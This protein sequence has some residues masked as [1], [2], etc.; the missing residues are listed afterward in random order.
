MTNYI[1]NLAYKIIKPYI[2]VIT[3]MPMA[4]LSLRPLMNRV[5]KTMFTIK[6]RLPTAVSM[7]LVLKKYSINS[8]KLMDGAFK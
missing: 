1:K 2:N 5:N 4:V 7:A 6:L 8:V 3:K